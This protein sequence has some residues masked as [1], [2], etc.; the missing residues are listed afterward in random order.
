M[1]AIT[2]GVLAAG[3]TAYS[4]NRN[5]KAAKSAGSQNTQDAPW[6][7]DAQQFAVNRS[8]EIAD[9]SYQ[10]YNRERVAGQTD[11]ERS[12]G[13]LAALGSDNNVAARRNLGAAEGQVDEL[14]GSDWNAE[15][16][17]KYMNPYV[18]GVIDPVQ[19]EAKR[20]YSD[21]L[22][23]LRARA[24]S[25][26]AF[27]SERSTMLES[28]LNRNYKQQVEDINTKGHAAAFTAAMQGWQADNQRRATAADAYRAV[29]GDISRL[30]TQQITDLMRT[31]QAERLLEQAELDFDYDQF[32][33]ERDWDID[34]LQPLL[35]SIGTAKGGNVT[36]TRTEPKADKLG[37]ILGAAGTL[38]GYF[39][40]TKGAE[41]APKTAMMMDTPAM[42]TG[43]LGAA[44][45]AMVA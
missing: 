13:N 38:I 45:G 12:A 14:A 29:G 16:M 27:G 39:G 26:N 23:A 35:A 18:Q 6:L 1:A 24:T 30:N 7:Q 4:A 10:P 34:N 15:T 33:E 25:M 28:N 9:R 42:N 36:T 32:I 8:R 40:G 11:N 5:S 19:R 2:T 31:G 37:T 41:T 3:A 20:G 17:G 21:D 22:A 43:N 44:N